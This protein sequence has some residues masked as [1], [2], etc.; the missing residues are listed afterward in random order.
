MCVV[1]D[2][3]EMPGNDMLCNVIRNENIFDVYGL[4]REYGAIET[5]Q[6]VASVYCRGREFSSLCVRLEVTKHSCTE[7]NGKSVNVSINQNYIRYV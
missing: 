2:V 3:F 4:M 1:R 6:N 7:A 5:N